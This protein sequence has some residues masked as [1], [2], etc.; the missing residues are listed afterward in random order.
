MSIFKPAAGDLFFKS[1]KTNDKRLGEMVSSQPASDSRMFTLAGYPD[2]EGIGINGGRKGASAAPDVIRKYFYKMTPS[3]WSNEKFELADQGNLQLNIPLEERHEKLK[4]H[5][6]EKLKNPNQV[7][8]GLGGGHDYGY[9]DGAGFL[10]AC[11][12]SKHKP[13]VINFDAHLD[14]RPTDQGLSSG[15]PYYRLLTDKNLPAFDFVEIGLQAQ[16]NS[17]QHLEWLYEHGGTALSFDELN[18]NGAFVQNTLERLT[19]FILHPRPTYLSVDIDAFSSAFAPGCSQSWSTGLVP[20]EFMNL[21]KILKKRLDVRLLG[22]YEVSP[23]LDT[24]DRT[25]KLAAQIL[26]SFIY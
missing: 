14:V 6:S 10:L 13:L 3:A 18:S 16:C 4:Q 23:P 17:R 9:P 25:S 19:P 26:H 7:W 24:D 8:L 22:I 2:D 5:I 15:T 21:L 20:N 1:P 12:N 11:R